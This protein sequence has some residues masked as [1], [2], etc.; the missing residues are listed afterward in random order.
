MRVVHPADC[1]RAPVLEDTR[2][3]LDEKI[4]K[5]GRLFEL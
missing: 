2:A 3:F 1:G 5:M 4:E